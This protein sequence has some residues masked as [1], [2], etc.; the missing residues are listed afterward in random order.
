[1]ARAKPV[2]INFKQQGASE[3]ILP[4]PLLTSHQVGWSGIYL[5]HH[6]PGAHDT[7]EICAPTH[8]VVLKLGAAA[9]VERWID[10][11]FQRECLVNKAVA[12]FPADVAFRCASQESCEFISLA[13]DPALLTQVSQEWNAAPQLV[14]RFSTLR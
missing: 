10:D 14:P 9:Q 5:E 3:Q 12:V 1:M 11:R 7:T 8:L 2:A 13:I 6:Y 4:P